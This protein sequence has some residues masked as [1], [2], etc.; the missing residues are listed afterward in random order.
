MPGGPSLAWEWTG[1]RL[2]VENDRYGVLPLFWSEG[3]GQIAVST[4]IDALLDAG[5][6]ARLDDGA[7]A[8]FLRI[9]FFVGEDTPF[10]AIRALPPSARLEWSRAGAT[11]Q[12]AWTTPARIDARRD[13]LI[14]RFGDAVARVAAAHAGAAGGRTALLLSGG[15]DSRHILFALDEAGARPRTC[16]TVEPYP[17]SGGDEIEIARR[18]AAA[19]GVEHVVL[20]QRTDRLSAER[21]K[22]A[23]T[24]CC[25]DEHVQFLPLRDYFAG[26]GDL[27]FDGLAGDVLSQSQ[28]LDADLHRLFAD[29]SF[30]DVA[31]RV[32]GDA[33]SIEP[34]LQ[35]L[36]TQEALARFP[37]SAAAARVAAEA[38]KHADAPNPIAS[39]F[40]F[41]RMRRE[42]ALAPYALLGAPV[43]T[44]FLDE[45]IVS[46]FLSA[47]FEAVRDR[48]LHTDLLERRYPRFSAIPFAGKERGRDVPARVRRDAAALAA[49]IAVHRGSLVGRAGAL[50][51]TARAFATG[52]SAHL[53]FLPRLAHLL[54]VEAR[55]RGISPPRPPRGGAATPAAAS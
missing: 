6:R 7:L 54:D 16:V 32:L 9:G 42:I 12:S 37:R 36:L 43:S 19:I 5:V 20:A 1:E 30:D 39:F 41:S 53:W 17:P 3:P 29:G 45:A 44:P 40:F 10:A 31:D 21:E 24:D 49:R 38:A 52:R 28:R 34:A 18:I 11:V 22:N 46:L 55:A 13:D 14:D 4:S 35:G 33:R 2:I 48:R 15:H 25:A 26:R 47:P 51:R 23:L 27:V 50:A 8:V